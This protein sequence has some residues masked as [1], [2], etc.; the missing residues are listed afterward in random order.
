MYALRMVLGVEFGMY[1][2]GLA[3]RECERVK[4]VRSLWYIVKLEY[5]DRCSRRTKASCR[6]PSTAMTSG[7]Q[8]NSPRSRSTHHPH[9]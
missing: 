7:G 2:W 1:V 4:R 8:L 3:S 9:S 6:Y 5:E